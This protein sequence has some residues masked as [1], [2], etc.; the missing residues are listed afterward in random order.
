MNLLDGII[1][2]IIQG[3]TE[4]LPVSSTAH[5]AILEHFLGV[6]PSGV[7]FEIILHLGTMLSIIIYFRKDIGA[8]IISFMGLFSEKYR[9]DYYE[10]KRLFWAIIVGSIPTAFIGFLFKD[11]IDSLFVDLALI[12]YSLIITSLFLIFSDFLKP[13]GGLN[14]FKGFIIGIFQGLAVIPGISRSGMTISTAIMCNIKRQESAKYSFLLSLPAIFGATLL[15]VK[16]LAELNLTNMRIYVFSGVISFLTGL[17]AIFL[18]LQFI[19][20]AKFKI[21]ALYC[22]ILGIY[23]VIWL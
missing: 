3:L 14:N 8:L 10:N 11:Y 13:T 4:F 23:L 9:I 12:G 5:L 2:G 7:L 20:R 15:H 18:V 22:L 19:K 1:L 21:F 17:L 16:E 6:N